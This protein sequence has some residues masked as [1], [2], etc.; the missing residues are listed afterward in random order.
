MLLGWAMRLAAQRRWPVVA[1]RQLGARYQRV[2]DAYPVPIGGTDD[3]G[4]SAV[5]ESRE[6]DEDV[7]LWGLLELDPLFEFSLFGEPGSTGKE[8]PPNA[9]APG[10]R[11]SEVARQVLSDDTVSH[12]VTAA[13]LRPGIRISRGGSP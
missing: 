7:A 11:L 10:D 5:P 9:A 1:Q 6:A 8:L 12:R 3:P 13:G 2:P 4:E